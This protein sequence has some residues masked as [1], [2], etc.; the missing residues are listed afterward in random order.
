[1][2]S[3]RQDSKSVKSSFNVDYIENKYIIFLHKFRSVRAQTLEAELFEVI[4]D[5]EKIIANLLDDFKSANKR[6]ENEENILSGLRDEKI[7]LRK[8][9]KQKEDEITALRSKIADN[10]RELKKKTD[11]VRDCERS[12]EKMMELYKVIYEY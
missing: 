1:M 6:V 10:E 2:G 7:E 4:S 11:A 12:K 8:K 9:V 3:Q 5:K